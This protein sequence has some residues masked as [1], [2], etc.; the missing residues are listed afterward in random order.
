M[1]NQIDIGQLVVAT[2]RKLTSRKFILPLAA[3]IIM[4]VTDMEW[5]Q[6]MALATA[7]VGY[8]FAEAAVDIARSK[9]GK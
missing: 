8:S 7:S 1:P 4:V 3:I 6:A 9:N 2:L 5:Q